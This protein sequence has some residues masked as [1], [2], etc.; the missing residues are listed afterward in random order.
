[1]QPAAIPRRPYGRPATTSAARR[2]LVISPPPR[3]AREKARGSEMA[4]L[5]I[6]SHDGITLGHRHRH[7]ERSH[8]DDFHGALPLHTTPLIAA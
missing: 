8:A 7:I 3:H 5:G 2:W 6:A 4:P 1:M